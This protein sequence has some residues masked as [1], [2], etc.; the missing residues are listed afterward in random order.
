M[1]YPGIGWHELEEAIGGWLTRQALSL[2]VGRLG[3]AFP[4][5][6]GAFRQACIDF[7]VIGFLA[8]SVV[9]GLLQLPRG[10]DGKL[11][12]CFHK[13]HLA[14]RTEETEEQWTFAGMRSNQLED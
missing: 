5:T 14:C 9:G 2:F 8:E 11:I 6:G 12:V 7:H 3:P 4:A 10:R 1:N 13:N